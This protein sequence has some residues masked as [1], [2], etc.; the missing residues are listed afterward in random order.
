M[1]V[2]TASVHQAV[3]PVRTFNLMLILLLRY[4]LRTMRQLDHVSFNYHAGLIVNGRQENH[5][6][7][8]VFHRSIKDAVNAFQRA[9]IYSHFITASKRLVQTDKTIFIN[10]RL[11]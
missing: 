10:F 6:T 3:G 5:Y 11:N 1:R 4:S 9:V 7:I 2:R 8:L